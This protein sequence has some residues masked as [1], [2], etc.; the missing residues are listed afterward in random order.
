MNVQ[1][2]TNLI[3]SNIAAIQSSVNATTTTDALSKLPAILGSEAVKISEAR[4]D[5]NRMVALLTH[6]SEEARENSVISIFS[7]AY[8]TVRGVNATAAEND[9]LILHDIG[10]ATAETAEIASLVATIKE[11]LE[12]SQFLILVTDEARTKAQEAYDNFMET[13]F[14]AASP[15][16]LAQK[17]EWE[18][19]LADAEEAMRDGTE[20][21]ALLQ[22][23]YDF[24]VQALDDKS[25]E[26]DGYIEAL[27][28]ES[29]RALLES[30]AIKINDLG[31]ANTSLTL[32][33]EDEKPD[34]TKAVS[35]MSV[36]ELIQYV[37]ERDAQLLR[38][39]EAKRDAIV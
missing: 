3:K 17:Q 2:N 31:Y 23:T 38:D 33:E 16:S 5:L 29:Y 37:Q 7:N 9:A 20:T 12:E 34:G 32:E 27:S 6:E 11:T 26:V 14:D 36:S 13:E 22:E 1:L 18:E 8:E 24:A 25:A 35:E 39:I 10:V 30:A 28:H 21:V 4:A 15:D 19:T